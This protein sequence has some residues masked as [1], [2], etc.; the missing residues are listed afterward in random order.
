M[1]RL[2][3]S[4]IQDQDL[5]SVRDSRN[6]NVQRVYIPHNTTVGVEGFRSSDLTVLG[7]LIVCGSINGVT[8]E[9]TASHALTASYFLVSASLTASDTFPNYRMLNPVGCV[10]SSESFYDEAERLTISV[11][12]TSASNDDKNGYIQFYESGTPF[13]VFA[14]SN[15][16]RYD[17]RV[18]S[19][20]GGNLLEALHVE[21][22]VKARNVPYIIK[23]GAGTYEWK[24][25]INF[26]PYNGSMTATAAGLESTSNQF[27]SRNADSQ[28]QNGT[29]GM[30]LVFL[31]QFA[32]VNNEGGIRSLDRFNNH[33][34]YFGNSNPFTLP[35][36]NPVMKGWIRTHSGSLNNINIAIGYYTRNMSDPLE[37]DRPQRPSG[38]EGYA[39]LRFFTG[40]AGS[41]T[42]SY[43]SRD[44]ANGL[45]PYAADT[46]WMLV[47]SGSGT[48]TQVVQSTGLAVTS[49]T[50][51]Y[52]ELTMN[53]AGSFS[54]YIVDENGTTGSATISTGI[55][56]GT[57]LG[58]LANVRA[59]SGSASTRIQRGLGIYFMQFEL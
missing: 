3:K 7:D 59:V 5:F 40:S 11:L 28:F 13:P 19:T 48:T 41:L 45:R 15:S 24:R 16:L 46:N 37:S 25:V 4:R 8:A 49:G 51:Y 34:D 39:Y 32:T 1:P 42:D 20:S 9:P 56:S 22:Q 21:G 10:S 31:G 52:F 54:A 30:Y 36:Q 27:F 2:D 18:R 53:S 17:D 6:A 38:N 57:N 43:T 55:T 47:A 58:F 23:T 29:F 12:P 14:A 35:I 26:F 44:G 50:D 33:P